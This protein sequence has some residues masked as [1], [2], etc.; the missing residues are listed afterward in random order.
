MPSKNDAS[1]FEEGEAQKAEFSQTALIGAGIAFLVLGA[2]IHFVFDQNLIY[3]LI[4]S[5]GLSLAG[6]IVSDSSLTKV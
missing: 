6:L 3:T 2:I 4:Y 1:D 5:S